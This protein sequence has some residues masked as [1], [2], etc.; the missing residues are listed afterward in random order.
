MNVKNTIPF[1]R[2]QLQGNPEADIKDAES[3][4]IAFSQAVYRIASRLASEQDD[5]VP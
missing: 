2:N 5:K 3:R 4:F 1:I